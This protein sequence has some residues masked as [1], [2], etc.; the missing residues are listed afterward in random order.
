MKR[1]HDFIAFALED[2]VA[3]GEL[4]RPLFRGIFIAMARLVETTQLLD[5]EARVVAYL[6]VGLTYEQIAE[7][8]KVSVNTVRKYV[9]RV[10]KKAGVHGLSELY[11][12]YFLP[13][14]G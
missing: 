8:T 4:E 9:T 14:P 5:H 1:L 2:A 3:R 13:W 6:L 12:K 7:R 11:A 10:Y